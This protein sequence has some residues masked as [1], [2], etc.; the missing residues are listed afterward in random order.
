MDER[1]PFASG[2][3]LTDAERP[4]RTFEQGLREAV[5]R[6]KAVQSAFYRRRKRT[7]ADEAFERRK[8]PGMF[9]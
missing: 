4:Q 2:Q 8:Y 5:A 1:L 3:P 6:P 9:D 7:K